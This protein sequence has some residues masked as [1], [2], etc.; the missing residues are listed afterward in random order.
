MVLRTNPCVT[1]EFSACPDR[2]PTRRRAPRTGAREMPM[3]VL[4]ELERQRRRCRRGF[5]GHSRDLSRERDVQRCGVRL[6][7]VS[8]LRFAV[9]RITAHALAHV[10]GSKDR[11]QQFIV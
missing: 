10:D 8:A 11:R 1:A 4:W 5:N 3:A 7:E 6:V 9:L 2:E